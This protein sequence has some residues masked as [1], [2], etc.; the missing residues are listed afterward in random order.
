MKLLELFISIRGN[1]QFIISQTFFR[2]HQT[3]KVMKIIKKSIS[4][5][6]LLLILG[7]SNG[8]MAGDNPTS[9][10][11]QMMDYLSNIDVRADEVPDKIIVDFMITENGEIIVL[12]TS[13]E[14]LDALIKGKLNYKKLQTKDLKIGKKYSLPI[15]FKKS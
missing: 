3:K 8:L 11:T 2:N 14:S 13:D 12:S 5:L 1:K 9:W 6:S 7:T 4:V 10:K 15:I